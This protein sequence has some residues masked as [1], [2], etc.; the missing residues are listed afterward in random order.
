[1]SDAAGILETEDRRYTYADYKAWELK[2]GERC[3]L[4]DGVAYAMAAPNDLHQGISGEIFRQIANYLRGKSCKVRPAP[5]DVRLFYAEDES[6]GTVVQPDISVICDEKKRGPE[7][8]RGAP[9]LVVEIL[10]P[11]NTADEYVRKCNLYIKAGVREY[12]ILEPK[13]KTVQT[14]VLQNGAYTG[15]VY[16]S[17]MALPSAV[18]EGLSITLQDVFAEAP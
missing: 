13:S 7:G 15:R 10:S 12:W 5:Y 17:G 14:F 11:S 16:D 6:D 3:E 1:M 8:C 9:D 4:I 2:E 18:L